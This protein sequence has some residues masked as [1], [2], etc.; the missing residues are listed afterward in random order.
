MSSV[1]KNCRSDHRFT[2]LDRALDLYEHTSVL[3]SN[4]KVFDRTYKSLID[5]IDEEA[6]LIYHCC[7]SANE[8]FDARIKDEARTRIKLQTEAIEHCRHLKSYVMIS[9]RKF[10]L[11]AKK[12]VY[13]TKL[14]NAALD[15]IT[16]WQKSEIKSYKDNF[17]L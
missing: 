6:M 13:W 11:R 1:R 17:G 2:V 12:V 4:D 9:G 3:I 15:K 8:D 7:R 10:R 16:A 14:I 5:R